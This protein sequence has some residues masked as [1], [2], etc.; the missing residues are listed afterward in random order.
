MLKMRNKSNKVL[1]IVLFSVF[2]SIIM[3]NFIFAEDVNYSVDYSYGGIQV[4]SLRYEPYPANPGEYV[5]VW[6]KAT[7]GNSV[8]YAKFELLDSFPFSLD[9]NEDAIREYE[10][11]SGDVVMHYKVRVS[12]DAVEGTNALKLEIFSDKLSSSG[13]IY[14]LDIDVAQAQTDFDL[15]VQD[16]TSSEVSLAIANTGKNTANS[17]IVRIPDQAGFRVTGTNGQMVGNLASGDYTVTSF[18]LVALGRSHGNLTVQIDYTDNIGVRR[19]VLKQVPFNSL[20]SGNVTAGSLPNGAYGN[21]Q[22][23]NLSASASKKNSN[24]KWYIITGV[25]LVILIGLYIIYKKRKNTH[26]KNSK[27]DNSETPEWIRKVKEKERK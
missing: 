21:F 19:S 12:Q 9:S 22:R 13:S 24:T 6:I 27:K 17:M 16:S 10:D 7:L 3:S 11:F 18:S 15:V 25:L 1:F 8:K 4:S 23:G 20:S 14:S 2:L 5:D 26:K